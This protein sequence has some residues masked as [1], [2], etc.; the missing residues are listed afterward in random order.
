MTG[1]KEREALVTL[2]IAAQLEHMPTLLTYALRRGVMG[3][4]DWAYHWSDK[5]H[6]LVYS[7]CAEVERLAAALTAAESERDRLR[8]AL[9]YVLSRGRGASGRIILERSEEAEARRIAALSPEQ[10]AKADD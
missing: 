7:A 6:R 8:G 5:P 3:K 10:K 9:E 1:K 4:G 2:K